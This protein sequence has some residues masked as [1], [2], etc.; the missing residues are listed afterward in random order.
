MKIL[1]L[2]LVLLPAL[3]T[4]QEQE[5][6]LYYAKPID[7]PAYRPPMKPV[8]RFA[9]LKAKNQGRTSWREPVIN[10]GNSVSFVVQEP[11]GTKHERRLYPDSA[12]WFIVLEGRIRFEI[13]KP[14]RSFATIEATKG[15]YV[16]VPERMLHAF[17]VIGSE[18]AIR[19]EVTS[20][21]SSTPV[22]EKR[23]AVAP[24]GTEYIPV[25]LSTGPNPLDVRHE[26]MNK[27]PWPEPH[28]YNVYEL[29]K[30]NAGKKGFTQEAMRANRAR[31]N[32]ICGYRPATFPT[33][34]GDRGHLHTDTA[35]SWVVMLGELR[36]VFEGDEKTAVIARQGDIIYA[37]PGTFHSP[38]FWGKDGLNCRLTNSTMPSL[39]HLY[40]V[41]K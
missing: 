8:T 37:V 13:E 31:G 29:E 24:K 3:A 7:R 9:D 33:D 15:S 12:A 17:E 16:F 4:A 10:D 32:F 2:C 28:H 11:S 23:P 25:T 38:Q 39:N 27:K 22:F 18:P 41:K 20:G 35:E 21:P 26:G 5:K 30:Q 36:W 6:I 40:D 14:D 1:A 34:S 19:Y